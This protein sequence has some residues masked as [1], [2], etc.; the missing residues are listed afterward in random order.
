[1]DEQIK[2]ALDQIVDGMLPLIAAAQAVGA[3]MTPHQGVP[4]QALL[5]HSTPPTWPQAT[6]PDRLA[7]APAWQGVSWADVI[8][9]LGQQGVTVPELWRVAVAV[10]CYQ[11]SA[12]NGYQ[13]RAGVLVDQVEYQCARQ[14]GPLAWLEHDWRAVPVDAEDMT[15]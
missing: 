12:G 13:V 6:A 9:V 15:L 8:A 11:S 4:L 14:V 5:S 1:M 2:A 7:D 3:S 10:D